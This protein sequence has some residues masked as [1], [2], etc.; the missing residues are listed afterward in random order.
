M[1]TMETPSLEK[2]ETLKDIIQTISAINNE[3][4]AQLQMIADSLARGRHPS[5]NDKNPDDPLTLMD[6]IRRERD[7]AEE[8]LKLLVII[9]EY[10]W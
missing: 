6:S 9:R 1:N 10:L 4:G 3:M 2:P 7:K 5:N 8:N